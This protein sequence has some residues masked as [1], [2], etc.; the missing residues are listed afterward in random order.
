[1]PPW[2]RPHRVVGAD[3]DLLAPAKSF[4][5]VQRRHRGLAIPV[6]VVRKF[7]DDQG[8]NLSALIAYYGFFSLFP[9]LLVFVSALGFVLEG[10]PDAQQAVLD[11]ALRQ[12]PIVGEQIQ[13]GTLEGNGVAL[14][15]GIV[16]ALLAGLAVTLAAQ[17]AFNRVYGI[18]HRRRRN[19]LSS[20]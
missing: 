19:Y 3:M 14:A 16:G 4:D 7:G 5:S 1:M 20:R 15:I 17:T 2:R 13:A 12:I 8:G 10:N 18:P 6:A 11:S 9:L